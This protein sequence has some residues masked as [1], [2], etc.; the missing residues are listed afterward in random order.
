[1]AIN[2]K[3]TDSQ[4]LEKPVAVDSSSSPSGVYIRRFITTTINED[5]QT[6]YKYKE[7]FLTNEEYA[8]YSLLQNIS[9]QVLG[10]EYSEAYLI[11]KQKL[12]TPVLY[13]I[14]NHYY[15][16]KWA[17]EIYEELISRGEKFPELFPLTIWDS[18]GEQENAE[19]MTWDDLKSLTIFLGQ[20]QE[21]YFNEY[22]LA[23]VTG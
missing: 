19:K 11:Y 9:E 20:L 6:V 8:Q 23:K 15:K 5:E 10:E 17:A 14:N 18:T 12:N 21:Q 13:S 16:P 7:A 1:M 2:L 3:W 4:S 22:K